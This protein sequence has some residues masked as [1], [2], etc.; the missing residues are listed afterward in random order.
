MIFFFNY[1]EKLGAARRPTEFG[2]RLLV[3]NEHSVTALQAERASPSAVTS[4]L[5]AFPE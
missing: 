1:V 4:F 5:C 3:T 2:F